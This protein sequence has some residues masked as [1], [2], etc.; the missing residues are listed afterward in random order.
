MKTSLRRVEIVEAAL[1]LLGTTPLAELTTRQLARHLGISQPALFR[2]FR[3][4]EAIL[5]SVVG[6]AHESLGAVVESVVAG[7]STA[8]DRLGALVRGL[9]TLVEAQPGL[10]RLLFSDALQADGAVTVAVSQLMSMQISLAA[11]LVRQAQ[12]E[13]AVARSE[14]AERYASLLVAMIQGLFL[15]WQRGATPSPLVD[16]ATPLLGVWL[17]GARHRGEPAT[18]PSPVP[19]QDAADPG[20]GLLALDVRPILAA[21]RDPLDDILA[22]LDEVGRAGV[23]LLTAPFR[24]A[25]LLALVG[26][27]GYTTLAEEVSKGIWEVEV[28]GPDAPQLERLHELP[29][30][31]PLER[32]LLATASLAPGASYLA[33][34]PRVPRL[35]LPRLDERGLAAI[36]LERHDGS[37][38]LYVRSPP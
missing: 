19:V 21:G 28:A 20:P 4:R 12:Q 11:E 3:S 32:V 8:V 15:Q 30:P 24:P 25:P 6:Y 1:E 27:R 36:T 17:D 35:L 10:P 14:D 13:G 26:G 9:L 38:L 2:H 31:E 23:V 5:V 29:A 22:A 16:M 37:A 33:Q 18:R 7:E 34:V